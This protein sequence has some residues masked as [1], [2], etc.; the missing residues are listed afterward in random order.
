MNESAPTPEGFKMGKLLQYFL[1]GLLV[2]AP[3]TITVYAIYWI[4]STIDNLIPIFTARSID[5]KIYVRNYGLGFLL[6][7]AGICLIG[8]FSSFLIKLK[9]FG[10]L[11]RLMAKTPGVR[12]IYT[13]VK[14][15]F[16]AFAGEKKK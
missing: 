14:D 5:G 11:E 8:F 7:I 4:V 15:F 2:I 9:F 16:E 12:F 13:T 3:V 1:Q 10:L 6:V